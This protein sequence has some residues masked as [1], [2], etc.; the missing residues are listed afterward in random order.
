MW[1]WDGCSGEYETEMRKYVKQQR[2]G[3]FPKHKLT[4]DCVNL[5]ISPRLLS[6]P[7]YH[8]F[9]L[10]LSLPSLLSPSISVGVHILCEIL[11]G[12]ECDTREEGAGNKAFLSLPP[13]VNYYSLCPFLSRSPLVLLCCFSCS[14]GDLHTEMWEEEG[15][16]KQTDE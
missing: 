13:P 3:V 5:S 2:S 8:S 14:H 9:H 1:E 12:N 15:E 16:K 11:L 4:P 7:L 10:P 6:P